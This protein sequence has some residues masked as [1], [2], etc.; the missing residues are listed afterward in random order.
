[1]GGGEIVLWVDSWDSARNLCK[2]WKGMYLDLLQ[3][4]RKDCIF[5]AQKG[6]SLPVNSQY[7]MVKT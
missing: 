5:I 2:N 7:G 6:A 1:M 3:H 4:K